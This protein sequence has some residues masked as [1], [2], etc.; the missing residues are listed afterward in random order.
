MQRL[1]KSPIVVFSLVA[2]SEN[3]DFLF[4]QDAKERDV[5]G[6][7]ERDHQFALERV[8][9]HLAASERV[10]FENLE[11]GHDRIDGPKWKV[12]ISRLHRSALEEFLQALQIVPGFS[13]EQNPP[14]HDDLTAL[15][16]FKD[17]MRP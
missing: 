12:E 8:V 6:L 14:S 5:A 15:F 10:A 1:G 17:S 4:V 16:C 13:C 3:G 2:N 7:A 11:F 9:A